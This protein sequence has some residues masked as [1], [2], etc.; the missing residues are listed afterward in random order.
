[1]VLGFVVG[2]DTGDLHCAVLV[3]VYCEAVRKAVAVAGLKGPVDEIFHGVYLLLD[4]GTVRLPATGCAGFGPVANR[5]SSGGGPPGFLK[6]AVLDLDSFGDAP[7]K[8]GLARGGQYTVA[9][10]VLEAV[11]RHVR[12]LRA[13]PGRSP[14]L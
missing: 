5:R 10:S 7:L 13:Q 3:L 6:A 8:F 1:M 14:S 12:R 11:S 4:L 9:V 2:A